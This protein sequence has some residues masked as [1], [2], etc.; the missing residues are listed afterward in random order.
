MGLVTRRSDY[1]FAYPPNIQRLDLATLVQFYRNRGEIQT[2][3]S[4]NF[5]ACA[6]TRNLIKKSKH[7]FGLHYSQE[8]WD[9]LLTK[10]SDGYPLTETELNILGLIKMPPGDQVDRTFI[11]HNVGVPQQLAYLIINDMKQFGFI[12]DEEGYLEITTRGDKA[13]DGIARRIYEKNFIPEMLQ[14]CEREEFKNWY[15]PKDPKDQIDLF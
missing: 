2:A 3:E 7:W 14:I 13:L 12:A 4:G 11:E 1:I 5:I 8:A 6:L 9:E 15:R 10:N